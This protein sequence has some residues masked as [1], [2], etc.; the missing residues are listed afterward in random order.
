MQSNKIQE[1]YNQT[2]TWEVPIS[3]PD[4]LYTDYHKALTEHWGQQHRTLLSN[5]HFGAISYLAFKEI[6]AESTTHHDN[7][8][9]HVTYPHKSAADLEFWELYAPYLRLI[10]NTTGN[11][12]YVAYLQTGDDCHCLALRLL[13]NGLPI[14]SDIKAFM[15]QPQQADANSFVLH[16]SNN[17]NGNKWVVRDTDAIKNIPPHVIINHSHPCEPTSPL[18]IFEQYAYTLS[19]K[20]DIYGH[21]IVNQ[22][23]RRAQL[24]NME[25]DVDV[26][27]VCDNLEAWLQN[28][29]HNSQTKPRIIMH[30]DSS[31][32]WNN[33]MGGIVT[34]KINWEL[35]KDSKV[36]LI[37]PC[38]ACLRGHGKAHDCYHHSAKSM[39]LNESHER[40]NELKVFKMKSKNWLYDPKK[41]NY[42]VQW[43]PINENETIA[44]ET[45]LMIYKSKEPIV[46]T[47]KEI[48]EHERTMTGKNVYMFKETITE[49]QYQAYKANQALLNM[50][51]VQVVSCKEINNGDELLADYGTT[52]SSTITSDDTDDLSESTKMILFV[53]IDDKDKNPAGKIN[54]IATS[55]DELKPKSLKDNETLVHDANVCFQQIFSEVFI[56]YQPVTSYIGAIQ[57]KIKSSTDDF[58]R[59]PLSVK[60]HMLDA[61]DHCQ[62]DENHSNAIWPSPI[63]H[64]TSTETTCS[65]NLCEVR[66]GRFQYYRG[67]HLRSKTNAIATM[68]EINNDSDNQTLPF[69]ISSKENDKLTKRIKS[70]EKRHLS[71][72]QYNF[73]TNI[74][75]K[76]RPWVRVGLVANSFKCDDVQYLVVSKIVL[77]KLHYSYNSTAGIP[78]FYLLR[79]LFQNAPEKS[80]NVCMSLL[81]CPPEEMKRYNSNPKWQEF[82]QSSDAPKA[83]KCLIESSSVNPVIQ[84]LRTL[85]WKPDPHGR[86]TITW[87]QHI[88]SPSELLCIGG[89]VEDESKGITKMDQHELSEFIGE[90]NNQLFELLSDNM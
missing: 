72:Y 57:T 84:D 33:E 45:P 3:L 8:G 82:L 77:D 9:Y 12:R 49:K 81:L 73:L 69:A 24:E 79:S 4:C 23:N 40:H 21:L 14:C 27:E 50:C 13:S 19:K 29:D 47:R 60:L 80:P 42:G 83:D 39:I 61:F 55:N 78:Q 86:H 43:Q 87:Q 6:L 32:Q 38:Q 88:P 10:E 54:S 85:E 41:T 15:L 1:F 35:N 36:R 30:V 18:S 20:L 37:A 51:Y 75:G 2:F 70:K 17:V 7:D 26:K 71:R 48:E 44:P 5:Q 11:T 90:L 76:Y 22:P 52:Y 56:D 65:L 53:G 62:V 58:Q 74:W 59:M 67:V 68:A 66:K 25:K 28:I 63:L 16:E 89:M 31:M 34:V 64:F 46:G